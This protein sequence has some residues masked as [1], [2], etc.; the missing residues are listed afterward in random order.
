MKPNHNP[1]KRLLFKTAFKK[2]IF[3]TESPFF[4]ILHTKNK[5]VNLYLTSKDC[6][7]YS[8]SRTFAEFKFYNYKNSKI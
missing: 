5:F 4:C 7:D 6:Y 2:V 1:N 8:L 3:L